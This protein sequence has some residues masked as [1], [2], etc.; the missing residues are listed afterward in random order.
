VA[1]PPTEKNTTSPALI[2]SLKTPVNLGNLQLIFLRALVSSWPTKNFNQ[3]RRGGKKL[4]N[5]F[6]RFYT[7]FE[8]FYIVFEYFQTF[9]NVFERF[10]H[11]LARLVL[12]QIT[13]LAYFQ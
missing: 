9:S 3:M 11:E 6:K 5:I 10:L 12:P 2:R 7:I 1:L 13:Y 8:R 4:S